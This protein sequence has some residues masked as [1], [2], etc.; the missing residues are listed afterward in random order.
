MGCT[1]FVYTDTGQRWDQRYCCSS[2]HDDAFD[3]GGAYPLI[4]V[5]VAPGK[6]VEVCCTVAEEFDDGD[7][8]YDPRLSE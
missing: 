2:C 7:L 8:C 4:G 1:D 6:D 5:E 3:Y